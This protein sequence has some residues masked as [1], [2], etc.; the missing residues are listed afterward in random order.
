MLFPGVGH[1][2]DINMVKID[3]SF[4]SRGSK[5]ESR[6]MHVR[7][8]ISLDEVVGVNFKHYLVRWEGWRDGCF[9]KFRLE[10]WFDLSVGY[11]N[12]LQQQDLTSCL[13]EWL[14]VYL[15][16]DPELDLKIGTSMLTDE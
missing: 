12:K 4:F 7:A 8:L 15:V 14:L 9:R 10:S 11:G 6:C 2:A 3:A 5:E 1:A 16:D 13:Q